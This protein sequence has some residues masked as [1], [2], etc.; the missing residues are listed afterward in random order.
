MLKVF[1]GEAYEE[2]ENW[3]SNI[4]MHLK[5]KQFKL[6]PALIFYSVIYFTLRELQNIIFQFKMYD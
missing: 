1:K 2:K 4:I 3:H 6:S 5:Y